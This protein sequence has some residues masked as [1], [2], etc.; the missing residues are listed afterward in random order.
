VFRDLVSVLVETLLAIPPVRF[1]MGLVDGR[2]RPLWAATWIAAIVYVLSRSM[3]QLAL[4]RAR[5]RILREPPDGRPLGEPAQQSA[6]P[7]AFEA[8]SLVAAASV[9]DAPPAA[10]VPLPAPPAAAVAGVPLNFVVGAVLIAAVVVAAVAFAIR[11]S[12]N[13]AAPAVLAEPSPEPALDPNTPIDL[14][15]R[16]GRPDDD[17]CIATFELTRGTG[18]RARLTAFVMDTSGAVMARDSAQVASAVAGMFVEFR[19]RH[20]TCDEI[21]DWQIQATT[22]KPRSP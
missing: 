4:R 20:V 19:F 3:N 8:S 21:D 2:W 9:A 1:V 10:D 18:T 12:P 11:P 14:R 22:L 16:S 6:P 15:Y 17:D 5:M 7:T 13:A